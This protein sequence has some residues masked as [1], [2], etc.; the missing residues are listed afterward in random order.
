MAKGKQHS[1]FE[2]TIVC[3]FCFSGF[4]ELNLQKPSHPAFCF[5]HLT[6]LEGEL[7]PPPVFLPGE[8]YGQN[9][10]VGYSPW[11]RNESDATEAT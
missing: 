5:M 1:L 11:G 7:A 4:W 10:L 3:F 8:S 9:S 2:N 6:Y